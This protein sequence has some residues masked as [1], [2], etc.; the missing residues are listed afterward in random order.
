VPHRFDDDELHARSVIPL[1]DAEIRA[2]YE[3]AQGGQTK[4][5]LEGVYARQAY[6]QDA[7]LWLLLVLLAFFFAFRRLMMPIV[8]MAPAILISFIASEVFRRLELPFGPFSLKE[9][10]RARRRRPE[11]VN[12]YEMLGVVVDHL[13]EQP[14]RYA[15]NLQGRIERD[16][17]DIARTKADLGHLLASIRDDIRACDDYDMQ[18]ILERKRDSAQRTWNRL[19][20]LDVQLALQQREAAEATAPV[21]KMRERFERLTRISTSLDRIERA[22]GLSNPA[23]QN[24]AEYR[25]ELVMLRNAASEAVAR[26]RD[27]QQLVD[28]QE[29]ARA[30]LD[31]D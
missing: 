17:Q 3:E 27:I 14:I 30:E 24:T 15:E 6:N 25:I 1:S 23:E 12:E 28:A 22:H 13:S 18:A 19:R 31:A 16:R 10:V 21:R 8:L 29:R 4:P 2:L 11:P 5:R 20:D 26:L 9:W 7:W